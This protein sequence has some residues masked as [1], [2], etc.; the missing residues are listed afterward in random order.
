MSKSGGGVV[1]WIG[2]RLSAPVKRRLRVFV[3]AILLLA[4][5]HSAASFIIGQ[6]VETQIARMRAKGEPTALSD[7]GR[8][9]VPDDQNAAP[10]YAKAFKIMERTGASIYLKAVEPVRNRHKNPPPWGKIRQAVGQF[11]GVVPLVEEAVSRPKCQFP[12]DWRAGWLARFDHFRRLWWVQY[13][14]SAKAML[15]AHDHKMADA[16]QLVSLEFE[17]SESLAQEPAIVS[18]MIRYRHIGTAC[19]SL[20]YCLQSGPI[21]RRHAQQLANKLALFD[22]VP[23]LTGAIMG[24]SVALG[25]AGFS[26]F[27]KNPADFCNMMGQFGT[28]PWGGS[29]WAICE[30]SFPGKPF[31]NAD[32]LFYYR[33]M[34]QV[35]TDSKLSYRE[36][37]SRR[38]ML[39]DRLG[40]PW[41]ASVSTVSITATCQ[42]IAMR[43]R[44]V[45]N[46]AMAQVALGLSAYHNNYGEYPPD[47]REL[48][49]RLKWRLPDDPFSGKPLRYKRQ[50]NGYLLYSIGQNLTDDGGEKTRKGDFYA[51]GDVVWKTD[52]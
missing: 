28:P 42:P 44:A 39:F 14:L 23:G 35:I 48:K 7:L 6:M 11:D 52:R 30:A 36:F 32:K 5:V 22:L 26:Y 37:N 20:Q 41:Y 16:L 43:D 33:T 21:D 38:G 13:F 19:V 3:T 46:L 8:P 40:Y 15:A 17:L 24:E 4:V 27:R 25:L 49:T 9:K 47:L 2:G 50:G 1:N 45:A 12:V 34:D 10:V 51:T 31:L 18:Q 29:V